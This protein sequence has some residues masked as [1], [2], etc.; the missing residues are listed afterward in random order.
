MRYSITILFITICSYYSNAQNSCIDS[1]SHF[2][3]G[4]LPND[5]FRVAKTIITKDSSKISIGFFINGPTWGKSFISR[6]DKKG[7][8]AWLKKITT[9]FISGN[10]SFESLGEA[11]NGNIF[12]GGINP[13]SA[14][15]PFFY[16]VFSPAGDPLYQNEIDISNSGT[17]LSNAGNIHFSLINAFGADSMLINLQ[18]PVVSGPAV[19]DANTLLTVGNNGQPGQAFTFVPPLASS[20]NPY[21][22]KCKIEGNIISLYGGS[23][24]VNTCM[25]NFFDQPAYAFLE[26][27][28]ITK[29]VVSK[30]AF[31]SP[32][33]GTD[34]FGNSLGEGDDNR[35][36][37]IYFLSNGNVLY[38]RQIWGL[39]FNGGDTLTRLF[40]LSE[41]DNNFNHV[42]SEYICTRKKFN[43]WFDWNYQLY[44]DSLNN[45][46]ISVFDLPNQQIYYAIGDPSGN[47]SLQKKITH[48]A[49][50]NHRFD[51]ESKILAPEPGYFTSF[52][53]ISGDNQ[54]TYI[55]NIRILSKDS[56][57]SCFGTD[58]NFLTNKAASV[59]PINWPGNFTV[60]QAVLATTPSNFTIEDYLL[61]RILVCNIVHK[62][63]TIKISA[64]DTVCNTAQ[65]VI[66]TA[67]KN[68][69]CDGKVNFIFDTTQV[70][71]FQQ[72][73]DT[74]IS[75][76][77]NKNWTGKIYA[78]PSACN[79]LIDSVT[80]YV[81][82]PGNSLNLGNDTIFCKDKSYLL[83]AGN[84]FASYAWQ[85]GSADSFF[86]A[87][88]P[89]T[90]YVTVKDY[91]NRQFSDTIKIIDKSF[92]P[93]FSKDMTICKNEDILLS[94][95]GNYLNY[96]WEPQNNIEYITPFKVRLSP[97]VNTSYWVETEIFA[98]CKISDTINI[99][100]KDCPQYIYFPT[101]FTPNND[102]LNDMLRPTLSGK[103]IYYS[104]NIY[105]RNGQVIFRSNNPYT[106]WDGTFKGTA[107]NSGIYIYLCQYRFSNSTETIAK[108]TI[109]LIR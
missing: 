34:Q 98:G 54:H 99:R 86:I 69:L 97:E 92:G 13:Y 62:C 7:E 65:P 10:T 57:V 33:I 91:C 30:K 35:N 42:K 45:R 77:F 103:L 88:S 53:I 46:I 21:Y 93:W 80:L 20:T 78:R 41:F 66:I 27:N 81:S 14:N 11:V 40:K 70:V 82:A 8:V 22:S 55:D 15:K 43:W 106:G 83:N 12:L 87:N 24:F 102:G 5:S 107:Q 73:N 68:P 72:L 67:H 25:L 18:H 16:L 29:Q 23:Q 61:Q 32:A 48:S 76:N 31:C 105:D 101:A 58:I 51:R 60:Q 6:I 63:D 56:A 79:K 39:D 52:N 38:T 89:G 84:A 94:L 109:M 50:R 85:N 74:T 4:S 108:G 9:P 96:N 3:Y 19:P 17:D 75:L 47:Y 1:S 90:Y 36:T 95:P 28:W 44:I 37:H 64:P 104:L 100:V 2:E 26:I 71:N 59:S 49:T